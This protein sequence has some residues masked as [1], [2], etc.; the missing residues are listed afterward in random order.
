MSPI[1]KYRAV[2]ASDSPAFKPF[3]EAAILLQIQPFDVLQ[4]YPFHP[5]LYR[6]N[7]LQI[8]R[9]GVDALCKEISTRVIQSFRENRA[10]PS[11][12]LSTGA[13]VL[14]VSSN[15]LF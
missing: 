10:R 15:T 9:Q 14:H 7:D 8:P 12:V 3:D 2:V 5:F 6:S 13:T 11:D 4:M 1:I